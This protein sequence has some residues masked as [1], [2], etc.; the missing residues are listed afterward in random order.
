MSEP[1]YRVG[2][3]AAPD[4]YE[5]G[6]PVG[7]GSEGVLYRGSLL[8]RET[9]LDVAIKML[10]PNHRT[11]LDEWARR[12]SEQ[13]ELL[14]SLQ[15]PGVVPVRDGFQGPLPHTSGEADHDVST[16]YL[17]MNWVDGEPLDVW[18]ARHP[19]VTPEDRLKLLLPIAGALDL[20]HSGHATGGTPVIHGD[21]KPSNI[22]VRTNDETVLVDFGLVR[23]LPDGQRSTGISGTPGYLAPEVHRSGNYSAA[24]DRYSLGAVAYVLLAGRAPEAGEGAESLRTDLRSQSIAPD[25]VDHVMEMLDSDP[26]KRPQVLAN[27][28]AQMRHSSLDAEHPLRPLAPIA[29]SRSLSPSSPEKKGPEPHDRLSK[30]LGLGRIRHGPIRWKVAL[31]V[32]F[33]ALLALAV[34]LPTT[35]LGNRRPIGRIST[36]PVHTR[37]IRVTTKASTFAPASGLS[38]DA[39]VQTLA[40]YSTTNSAWNENLNVPLIGQIESGTAA[41]IDEATTILDKAAGYANAEGKAQFVP[42]GYRY[43]AASSPAQNSYPARVLILAAASSDPSPDDSACSALG[44]LLVFEKDATGAAWKVALE[45]FVDV[46][47]VPPLAVT[48]GDTGSFVTSGSGLQMSPEEVPLRLAQTFEADANSGSQGSF[49][50]SVAMT[51]SQCWSANTNAVLNSLIASGSNGQVQSIQITP[52]VPND[53]V[54]FRTTGGGAISLFSL[55]VTETID[56]LPGHALTPSNKPGIPSSYAIAAGNYSSLTY[57]CVL[58][59]AANIFSDHQRSSAPFQLVGGFGGCNGETGTPEP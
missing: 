35:L 6:T 46:T 27:W 39:A 45:P 31:V 12:W 34:A 38:Q 18:A 26:D 59:F 41:Q 49:G 11:R 50:R 28:C 56:A 1:R 36:G 17:V 40:N 52:I 55:Q 53:L 5:I 14:R 32:G 8:V 19:E 7:A 2:P 23:L 47:N 15:A 20:M 24:A 54:S 48:S 16:F 9:S 58:E 44:N 25:L 13:V 3:A 42:F 43:I 29:A 21:I 4:R 22:L 51:G 33:A 10:H 37:D 30:R 57:H